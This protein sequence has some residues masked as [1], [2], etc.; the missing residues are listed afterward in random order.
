VKNQRNGDN[1][2]T[3]EAKDKNKDILESLE[4]KKF[5]FDLI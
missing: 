2:T 4:F 1:T 5:E 3:T